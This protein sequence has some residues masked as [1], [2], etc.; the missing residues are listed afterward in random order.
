[1][2]AR[3]SG[4]SSGRSVAGR[5]SVKSSSN[6]NSGRSVAGRKSEKSNSNINSNNNS[7]SMLGLNAG[8]DDLFELCHIIEHQGNDWEVLHDWFFRHST[9]EAHDA[10]SYRG[11]SGK[12][13]L[14]VVCTNNAPLDVVQRVFSANSDAICWDDD[15]G[16]TP[17]H[18]AC[19]HGIDEEVLQFLVSKNPDGTKD[20]DLKGRN[21]LHFAVGNQGKGLFRS[22]IFNSLADNGAVKVADKKGMCPLHY[23]C[24]YGASLE[25][26]EILIRAHPK[27]LEL[28]DVKG[29]LPLHY[30]LINCERKDCAV[31][32]KTLLDNYPGVAD[33]DFQLKRHPLYVLAIQAKNLKGKEESK[34]FKANALICLNLF[35]D[36]GPAPTT[37]FLSALHTLP[38]WLLDKAVVHPKIQE[39]L[40]HKVSKRFPTAVMMLDFYALLTVLVSFAFVVIES[41]DRRSDENLSDSVKS[42]KLGEWIL[43]VF[44]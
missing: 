35:L 20:T 27:A 18:Y 6:S 17:L 30:A 9:T 13:A 16:W 26:L 40:N 31:V 42:S 39:C 22:S 37:I 34:T 38:K 21:P 41:I 1:M 29:F 14:H 10:A 19:H 36:L 5:N 33:I 28:A 8:H 43:L 4:L 25:T 3:S 32:V 44:N 2:S 12:S 23:A 24:A 7:N 11:R 15:G